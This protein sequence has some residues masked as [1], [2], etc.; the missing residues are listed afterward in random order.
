MKI[1]PSQLVKKK[2]KAAAAV[3]KYRQR[4]VKT[5]VP[6]PDNSSSILE[7]MWW[8]EGTDSHN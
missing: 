7:P 6:T 8:K 2:K 3:V 4:Q 5:L 1:L